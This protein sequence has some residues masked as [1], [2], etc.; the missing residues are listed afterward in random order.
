MLVINKQIESSIWQ[1]ESTMEIY[2]ELCVWRCHGSM[3]KVGAGKKPSLVSIF[4]P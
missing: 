4:K 2:D 3:L 1:C